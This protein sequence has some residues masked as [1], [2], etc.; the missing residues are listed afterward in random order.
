MLPFF[1]KILIAI[2]YPFYWIGNWMIT[3][4]LKYLRSVRI[5]CFGLIG[6]ITIT[7]VFFA[8]SLSFWLLYKSCLRDLPSL[9]KIYNLP[10]LS[11]RIKDKD[12][13]ILY[14]FYQNEHRTW[15]PLAKIPPILIQATLAI[16]DKEFFNHHGF[17]IKGIVR[18][19]WV[20]FRDKGNDEVQGGS[21]IT[22]Q[23]VKNVLLG[24]EKTW[25]RKIREIVLAVILEQ[26]LTKEQILER[27]FNQVPYGGEIYGVQEASQ[28]YFAKDVWDINIAQATFLAGLPAAPSAYSPTGA[29]WEAAKKRQL[30]VLEEMIKNHNL[31]MDEAQQVANTELVIENSKI[32]IEAPHF[33]FYVKDFLE[34]KFGY[35]RLDF[36]GLNITTSLDSEL[37]KFSDLAVASEVARVNSLRIK[38]GAALILDVT[39]GNVLAMSGSKSYYAKD[40]DGKFNVTTALRQ[41]GSSIKPINYVLALMNGQ[42][43]ASSIDDSPITYKIPGQKPYTPQNYNKKFLGR[44]SLK[45]ALA[46]SLNI[47]SVKLLEQNGVDNMINLA[48]KMGINSWQ[49]RSRFGL[50][51]ALGAGEVQMTELAQAYS[52]FANLGKKVEVNPVVEIKNYLGET[53]YQK[54]VESRQVFEDKY[55]FLINM[56]LSDDSARAPIFGYG[57]KLKIPGKTV[58]VKTGTTNSLRD[59]WAIGWTPKYLVASWVGNND[60]TPMSWVASGV[61]GAT[62]IW[63]QIVHKLVDNRPDETW[64]S[65]NGVI[66]AKICGKE[67]WFVAG[68]EK[69]VKCPPPP[70]P[71]PSPGV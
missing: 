21:T 17:S 30:R 64:I 55:A 23:L 22:Q 20:N 9:E 25:R 36:A 14:V 58:A 67:E 32:D 13:R 42:T 6:L 35:G 18:A 12:G 3:I 5:G 71:T 39:N 48:E 38:N 54:Q 52:I 47:P 29:N 11:S 2:G 69:N 68:S 66:K 45:T 34:K 49:D 43:L 56:A 37:Q 41:P 24:K 19:L 46:S 53:I 50:S 62:P 59:N 16:E 63:N 8:L 65:P 4:I 70:S 40:I 26:K 15:V 61:S 28:K 60:N 44:V 27:Y 1:A 51:L 7:I 57:S 33:V 31:T 10:A